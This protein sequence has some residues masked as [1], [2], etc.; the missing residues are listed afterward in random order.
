MAI[1]VRK[2]PEPIKFPGLTVRSY[3][4]DFDSSY[5]TGGE[6]W[7]ISADFDVIKTAIFESKGGYTF[8]LTS[9]D[10]PASSKIKA[11]WV[12]TTVD[13][14]PLAEITNTTDI[15]AV[16]KVGVIIIGKKS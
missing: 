9:K 13:G 8:E 11:Y 15:S 4:V 3:E 14:A 2:D 16:T 12:D 5:P 10:A 1:T 7:D 6:V